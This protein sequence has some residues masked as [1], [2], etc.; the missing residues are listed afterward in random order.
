MRTRYNRFIALV[1]GVLVAFWY[2]PW[3]LSAGWNRHPRANPLLVRVEDPETVFA[4][5]LRLPLACADQ[6]SLE[7][8]P[9]LSGR[10]A[11]RLVTHRAEIIRNARG[12][13]PTKALQNVFGVGGATAQR[14]L[15]YLDPSASCME[16]RDFL[17]P[18][19]LSRQP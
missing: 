15:T 7:Q 19:T 18:F 4:L 8:I 13:G 3:L 5:G 6:W 10:V 14:L 1:I 9:N 12:L 2:V 16:D 11:E 17:T